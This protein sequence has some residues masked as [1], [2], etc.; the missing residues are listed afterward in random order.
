MPTDSASWRPC[1]IGTPPDCSSKRLSLRWRQ[2]ITKEE[3]MTSNESNGALVALDLLL[4]AR[5]HGT[6]HAAA[7][8]SESLVAMPDDEITDHAVSVAASAVTMAAE[9]AAIAE[10]LG[11]RVDEALMLARMQRD[12]E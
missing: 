5:R 2:R 10:H 4:D 11:A 9:M 7:T 6:E 8:F 3:R 1:P 12:T